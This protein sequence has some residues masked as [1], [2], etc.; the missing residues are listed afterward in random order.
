MSHTYRTPE[1]ELLAALAYHVGCLFSHEDPR[2]DTAESRLRSLVTAAASFDP[3]GAPMM[4]R[5]VREALASGLR[6]EYVTDDWGCSRCAPSDIEAEALAF[7]G[8]QA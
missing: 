5:Q 8:L 6:H 1:A 7:A 4:R 3:E 2:S